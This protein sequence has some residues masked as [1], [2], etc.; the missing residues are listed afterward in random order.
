MDSVT[1]AVRGLQEIRTRYKETSRTLV[2][3]ETQCETFESDVRFIQAWLKA[4]EQ[5]QSFEFQEQRNSLS[6]A[7]FTINEAMISL[8]RDITNVLGGGQ[9]ADWTAFVSVVASKYKWNEDVMKAHLTNIRARASSVQ[10]ALSALRGQPHG[11]SNQNLQEAN[12]HSA[13]ANQSTCTT[14]LTKQDQSG[15]CCSISNE[16]NPSQPPSSPSTTHDE[17]F[18][19][20]E[21]FSADAY[22]NISTAPRPD[23]DDPYKTPYNPYDSSNDPYSI[24]HDTYQVANTFYHTSEEAYGISNDHFSASNDPYVVPY[25]VLIPD[26][27]ITATTQMDDTPEPNA[28]SLTRKKRRRPFSSLNSLVSFSSLSRSRSQ[29]ELNST[30]VEGSAKPSMST[31]STAP[32]FSTEERPPLPPHPLSDD[33]ATQ[34]ASTSPPEPFGTAPYGSE[35]GIRSEVLEGLEVDLRNKDAEGLQVDLRYQDAEG[36]ELDTRSKDAEGL[37]VDLRSLGAEGLEVVSND[38]D[39]KGYHSLVRAAVNQSEEMVQELLRKL[40]DLEVMD[41]SKRTALHAAAASGNNAVCSLL[42]DK[43]AQLECKDIDSKTALQMAVEGG[44]ADTVELLLKRSSLKPSDQAFHEAWY[45]AV[46]AGDIR[47]AEKFVEKGATPK[48]LK[49][50]ASTPVLWAAKSGKLEMLDYLLGKKFSADGD[51]GSSWTAL[52]LAPYTG[53][54]KIVE[55]LLE[56]KVYAKAGTSQ[57]EAPLHLTIKGGDMATAEILPEETGTPVASQDIHDQSPL[58]VAARGGN[59]SIANALLSKK[60]N[61]QAQNKF[62]WQSL[63][64][65]VAYGQK[66]LVELLTNSGAKTDEKLDSKPQRKTQINSFLERGYWAEARWPHSGSRPLHLATEFERD[67]I[68]RLLIEKGARIDTECSKGW[69]PLHHAAFNASVAIVELLLGSGAYVH[70]VNSDGATPLTELLQNA[71]DTT[72]KRKGDAFRFGKGSG[73]SKSV[74]EKD[75]ALRLVEAWQSAVS[76]SS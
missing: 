5:R 2:A 62:G 43:G 17:Q 28:P 21:K 50:T 42:L 14:A 71:A 10:L 38:P 19:D 58:H 37:Q 13:K 52:H 76:M 75:E 36:L 12:V 61:V 4:I 73:K 23:F 15:N 9:S 74:D 24:P 70:A 41:G 35:I 49:N 67:D 65:A 68:T 29:K 22:Y 7:L 1:S 20:T 27:Q 30:V 8:L 18:R 60:A 72:P 16:A 40:T 57:K 59:A 63:H 11:S 48:G 47:V 32:D 53:H 55:R 54:E 44:H 31:R 33:S 6:H 56:K 64:I 34:Q 45:A 3:I 25:S 66:E 69:R 26:V 46:A 51:D 39:E